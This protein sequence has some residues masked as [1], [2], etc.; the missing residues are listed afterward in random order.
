MTG[1]LQKNGHRPALSAALF[2]LMIAV[3][4]PA[5]AADTVETWDVGATDVDFYCG[6]DGMGPED[7]ERG[8]YGDI[9]LGYGLVERFSAYLGTTL[10]ANDHF[11]EGN[12]DVY[13][14]IFGTPLDTDHFDL[15]LFLDVGAGG[16]GF[17]EFSLTPSTELNLD[18]EP[19]LGSWGIY[20]RAGVPVYGR[21]EQEES[22][23]TEHQRAADVQ[24]NPGTY[25]TIAHRHQVLL[26]YD[27][28]FHPKAGPDDHAVDIGGIAL[29]YNVVLADPIELITQVYLDIPQEDEQAA[30]GVMVGFIA[31][32]PSPSQMQVARMTSP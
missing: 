10:S 3:Y 7:G 28:A 22:G 17:D 26:E 19:D 32:M 8:L 27:M 21:F 29:G 9:M 11:T 5:R 25:L 1:A 4:A 15:D 30:V 14:G 6:F 16:N 31:T 23:N 13:L 20:L 18:L 2:V 24:L 12:A